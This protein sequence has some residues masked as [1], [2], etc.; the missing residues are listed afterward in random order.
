MSA[1]TQF[2]EPLAD[3][4]VNELRLTIEALRS[5]SH[6]LRAHLADRSTSIDGWAGSLS[7]PV[8][9]S[10]DE[11]VAEAART[12]K[13]SQEIVDAS[14]V[15]RM[16]RSTKADHDGS[17]DGKPGGETKGLSKRERE[18]LAL[19]VAGR[20]SKQIAAALGI[21]FKTAVTHRTSIMDK[22]EVHEIASLV[23]EAIR[24]RLA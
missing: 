24:Q 13:E 14:V 7:L 9:L 3:G 15:L 8:D 23:R 11:L 19:I 2:D 12:R 4:L 17:G 5:S 16:R 1:I 6:E 20:T 10:A 22:M 21:S 18:V